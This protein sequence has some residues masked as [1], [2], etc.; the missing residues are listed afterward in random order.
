MSDVATTRASTRAAIVDAAA[1]LLHEGGTAAVTTRGV[2][3]RAG[4][5]APTI[6]RLFGDKDGLLEA[7]AE[8]VMATFVSAKTAAVEAATAAG[9]DPL[10]DLRMSWRHQISF[11]LTNPAVF[12][13]LSDPDRV[14]ASPAA[15]AGRS[16]LTARVRRLAMAGRLRVTEQRA[17]DLIQAAGVGTVQAQ[18][19]TP[20]ELR[21]PELGEA[22]MDA[23]LD[24][25]LTDASVEAPSGPV[26]TAV[27][28]R[29]LAPQ[30]DALSESERHLLIEWLD[31]ITDT[32]AGTDRTT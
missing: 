22:M 27:A 32:S 25:I 8:H 29:A 10:E 3:E 15:K 26:A 2:A 19:A 13:L 11:G 9:L 20:A 4:V 23:V 21:D 1:D 31:R 18:L 12:R 28:L 30:L 24:R 6:Y 16:V 5:Q 17:V 7:V 14:G